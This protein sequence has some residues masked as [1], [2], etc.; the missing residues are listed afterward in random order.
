MWQLAITLILG[1]I[2]TQHVLNPAKRWQQLSLKELRSAVC[3]LQLSFLSQTGQEI[4]T[5]HFLHISHHLEAEVTGTSASLLFLTAES[6]LC[7]CMHC[8]I[9][10]AYVTSCILYGLNKSGYFLPLMKLICCT[11]LWCHVIAVEPFRLCFFI[12]KLRSIR[13]RFYVVCGCLDVNLVAGDTSQSRTSLDV[14]GVSFKK[15]RTGTSV[16][17]VTWKR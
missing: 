1:D 15:K 4:T 5:R 14:G 16:K 6:S 12:S 2:E 17:T 3:I 10:G 7:S 9:T 11:G 13:S 8:A